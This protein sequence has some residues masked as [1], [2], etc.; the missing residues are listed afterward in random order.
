MYLCASRHWKIDNVLRERVFFILSISLFL[1]GGGRGSEISS[2]RAMSEDA[3]EGYIYI[4][5]RFYE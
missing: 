4:Y 2:L 5:H 3:F 1:L